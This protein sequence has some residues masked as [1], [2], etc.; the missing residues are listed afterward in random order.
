MSDSPDLV[1]H[2]SDKYE[3]A[4]FSSLGWFQEEPS[5][6]EMVRQVASAKDAIVDVGAGSS[7]LVDHLVANGFQDVTCLD[8]SEAPFRQVRDRLGGKIESVS[9]VVADLLTWEPKQ[10]YDL[11]HDR[12]MFHF[13]T[14]RAD[15]DSYRATL[16]KALKPGGHAIV[17]TFAADGP[18]CCA[19][20]PTT[21]FNE[22]QLAAEFSD[23]LDA[24]SC[25]RIQSEC[26]GD[27]RPYSVCTFRLK[28]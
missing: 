1:S 4:A 26:E 11:W 10:A 21:R 5:T 2:W 12:A 24:V 15:R 19:G 23:V 17:A 27:Q 3:S 28:A 20:L 14:D 18:E 25:T 7:F 13:M 16:L 9:F 22:E 8:L 6:L